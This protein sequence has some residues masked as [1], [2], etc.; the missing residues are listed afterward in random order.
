MLIATQFSLKEATAY[1][2]ISCMLLGHELSLRNFSR[3]FAACRQRIGNSVRS[4][5]DP[6]M[7]PVATFEA[8]QEAEQLAEAFAANLN[9]KAGRE[10]AAAKVVQ[11]TSDRFQIH[12]SSS[13]ISNQYLRCCKP[14]NHNHKITLCQRETDLH[15]TAK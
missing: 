7:F 5:I 1:A 6:A 4:G 10:T 13:R 11:K 8:R 15:T 9:S 14:I 12:W 3:T 2:Y